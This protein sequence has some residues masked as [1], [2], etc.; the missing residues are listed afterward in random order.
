LLTSMLKAIHKMLEGVDD[1]KVECARDILHELITHLDTDTKP[2]DSSLDA[3]AQ[4]AQKELM[5]D[6]DATS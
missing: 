3:G 5:G 1:S 2:V 6:H 4:Q